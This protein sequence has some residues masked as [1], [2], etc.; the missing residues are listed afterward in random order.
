MSAK[1][2]ADYL[3]VGT[4]AVG[5][6][7]VDALIADSDA[8]VVMID[9]RHAPGGH[10]HDAY[11]FVRL[12]QP[13]AYYG[14][15]SLPLG[16][17]RIDRSGTNAGLL[18]RASAPEICGYYARVMEHCLV[19]SGRVEHHPLCEHLGDNRFVS[20]VTG[21]QYEVEVGKAVVDANY[22]CPAVPATTPPPFEVEAGARCIA[23]GELSRLDE[24]PSGYV[25]I[26]AGKTAMDACLWLLQ[27][28]VAPERIRWIKPRESWLVNREFVQSGEL[29]GSLVQGLSLQMQAAAEAESLPDL[30]RRLEAS[31]LL[32]RV[33]SGVEPTMYKAATID[34]NEL[35]QLRSM[36]EVVR[37]GHVRRIER[38]RIVL[39]GGSIPTD[40]NQLHVHCAAA[41]LNPAP[42]VPIFAEGRITLQPVRSGLLPFNAAIAGYI[43]ATRDDLADKNRLCP[44]NR[45]PDTPLDWLRGTVIQTR[46][47]Y[48]WSRQPDIAAWLERSRLNALRGMLTRAGDARVREGLQGYLKHVTAG[49]GELEAMIAAAG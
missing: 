33:D 29:V 6:A 2:K 46:A 48:R 39:E 14:V 35:A 8:R 13:S 37:L 16:E 5:M 41:G 23:V 47:D 27:N 1:L 4:G 3:V 32:L 34:A 28:D 25:I 42:A 45:L 40:P 21:T 49:L 18:E 36:R 26:G 17:D 11:S 44:V 15:N 43:E 10:W 22:L 20:H 31:R 38:D 30:F 12:H 24:A 19:P 9:R 7:F